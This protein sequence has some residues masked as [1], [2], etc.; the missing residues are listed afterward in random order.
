MKKNANSVSLSESAKV[1][2]DL[3]D[4]GTR[5]GMAMLGSLGSGSAQMLNSVLSLTSGQMASTGRCNCEIPPPCWMPQPLPDVTSHGCPGNVATIRFVITNCSMVTRKITISTTSSVTG[6]S[7]SV[8][9]LTLGPMERGVVAV[10]YSIPA[11]AQQGEETEI[12]L[13]IQGCKLHFLRWTVKVAPGC[14]DTCDEVDVSDCPDLVHHWYDHFYCPR[15]CL[16]D[17]PR[18]T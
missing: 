17:R 18:G 16:H 9:D 5:L 1:L 2:G 10:S 15:P 11:T 12:P 6:L 4:Q 7:F 3:F 8:T 14:A 13:W